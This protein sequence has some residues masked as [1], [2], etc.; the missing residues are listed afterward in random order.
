MPHAYVT[1]DF[2]HITVPYPELDIFR[3]EHIVKS[4]PNSLEFVLVVLES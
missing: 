4:A 1:K 2:I 3:S